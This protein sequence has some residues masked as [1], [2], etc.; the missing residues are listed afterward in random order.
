[1]FVRKSLVAGVVALGTAGLLVCLWVPSLLGIGLHFWQV[2]GVPVML[3]L[4]SWLLVP[5]WTADRLLALST[6]LK[7][8]PGRR[9]DRRRLVVSRRRNP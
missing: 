3:L 6:V 4:G 9:V 5:A 7:L 8:G 1:M 2:A